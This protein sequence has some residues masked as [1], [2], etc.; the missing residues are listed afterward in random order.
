MRGVGT[1][2]ATRQIVGLAYLDWRAKGARQ[3]KSVLLGTPEMIGGGSYV[4]VDPAVLARTV[5]QFLTR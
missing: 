5:H 1:D 4:V 3:Y 2:L